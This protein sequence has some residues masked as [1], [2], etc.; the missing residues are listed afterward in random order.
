MIRQIEREQAAQSEEFK[1]RMVAAL[2][3]RMATRAVSEWES[4]LRNIGETEANL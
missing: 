4:R 1:G 3:K 2:P